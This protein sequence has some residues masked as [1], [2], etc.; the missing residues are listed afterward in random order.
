MNVSM[1]LIRMKLVKK[2]MFSLWLGKYKH[3]SLI[4]SIHMGVVKHTWAFQK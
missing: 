3:I 4:Q 2:L 1:K